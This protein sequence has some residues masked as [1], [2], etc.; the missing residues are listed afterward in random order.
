M[1]A[2]EI[3]IVCVA[4]KRH[5]NIHV[6]INSIL[7]QTLE[8]WKLLIIHDGPDPEMHDILDK[9]SEDHDE[10]EYIFTDTRYNDYGHTLRDMG[11]Q[12]ADTEFLLLTNDD[13]Y[14]APVFLQYMFKLIRT[15]NLDFVLCNMIHSHKNPGVYTQPPYTLFESFPEIKYIDMGNFIVKT[16]MA[17]AVGFR[18]KSFGGDG[19]FVEDIKQRYHGRIRMGKLDNVLFMHN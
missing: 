4:Y 1:I 19:T 14:Y 13:N 5:R 15:N 2:K 6:L 9:Y 17:K 11:I 8:N 16:E 18:D 3:T 10:I 12:K 7:C